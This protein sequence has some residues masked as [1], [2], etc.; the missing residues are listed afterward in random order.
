MTTWKITYD[1]PTDAWGYCIGYITITDTVVSETSTD[2]CPQGISL[3][4]FIDDPMI[5]FVRQTKTS[6]VRFVIDTE[7]G[8]TIK[9]ERE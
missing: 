5:A 3:E 8:I 2:T 9:W 1:D 6:V 7:N 4:T